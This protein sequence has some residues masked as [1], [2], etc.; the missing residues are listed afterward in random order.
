MGSEDRGAGHWQESCGK[1]G[2]A[3]AGG[4]GGVQG[5]CLKAAVGA[6][7]ALSIALSIVT[8][9]HGHHHHHNSQP[10]ASRR[11]TAASAP[12]P[13]PRATPRCSRSGCARAALP[14]APTAPCAAACCPPAWRCGLGF[15]I[16]NHLSAQLQ[17]A[18]S[19]TD[20]SLR[21]RVLSSCGGTGGGGLGLKTG[22][23]ATARCAGG[24][25]AQGGARRGG[26]GG[27]SS[28]GGR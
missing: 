26:G 18:S 28:A 2:S 6:A 11:A 25:A 8:T 24:G 4:W 20:S 19:S 16:E 9:K 3:Q 7:H 21:S 15:K 27:V 12:R 22:P 23:C 1:G 13:P 5:A 14:R 17:L 10:P